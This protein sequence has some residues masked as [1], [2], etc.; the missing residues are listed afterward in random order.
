MS[1]A[2]F[3]FGRLFQDHVKGDRLAAID[4]TKFDAPREV[5]Y[6]ELD[7]CCDAVAR[8]IVAAGFGAGDRI[9]ARRLCPCPG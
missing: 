5:T 2:D 7:A 4:L 9:D 3:N 6:R 8:G 1:V